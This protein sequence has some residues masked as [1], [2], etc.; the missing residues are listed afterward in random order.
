VSPWAPV[1]NAVTTKFFER[2][3]K[4]RSSSASAASV[5]AA[6]TV[7]GA[8]QITTTVSDATIPQA[9]LIPGC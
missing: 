2:E 4:W 8:A 3:L 6:G 1:V 5:Q 9:P 7:T